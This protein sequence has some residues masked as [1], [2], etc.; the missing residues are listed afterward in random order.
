MTR[1]LLPRHNRYDYSPLPE[2][3]DYS[4]PG[5][6]RLAFVVTTNVECFAFGAGLG[7][8]PAKTG[9]PQTHR[10][11]SWRDYGNRIGIWRFF[12]LFD[13][14]K[15]P[16]A[17]NTNSLLYESAPQVMDAIR[18]R[19]DE[20]VGHGRSNA[21]NHRGMWEADE[22]R[23][24]REVTETFTRHEGRPPAGWMGS[25]AY[26]TANTPDL[27]KEAGYRY[28]MDWPMDDQPVWMRTRAGPILSVPYPIEL[29]DSQVVIHRKQD[30]QE[31]C[32]MIINQ[33]DEMVQQCARHPLVMNISVHPYIFGQPF[34]LRALR[35]ALAHCTA[36]PDRDRVWWTRPMDIADYCYSLPPGIIPGS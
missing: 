14:L 26:E 12:D 8:D 24:I 13:E 22:E 31:F 34:R 4:W 15:L 36:H 27:L 33:F 28:I 9:E 20:I 11:Y 21:E 25:G 29:N 6:K 30:G 17:H 19:G 3:R 2:R 10:N 5:G 35:R 1:P 7:H 32:D 23:I 16:L 18:R